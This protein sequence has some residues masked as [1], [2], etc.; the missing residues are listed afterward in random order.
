MCCSYLFESVRTLND[1][2]RVH[3]LEAGLDSWLGQART[4]LTRRCSHLRW[5]AQAADGARLNF[6]FKAKGAG[7][8]T[9]SGRTSVTR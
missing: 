9:A 4:T 1:D 3:I 7:G 8:I 5:H 2:G 6:G